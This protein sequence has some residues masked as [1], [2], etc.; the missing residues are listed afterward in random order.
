MDAEIAE[1]LLSPQAYPHHVERVE[2]LQTHISHLFFAGE[3]VY[4]VKKPVDLGF[5]DFT[6]LEKRRHFCEEEVRL[7]SRLSPDMYLGVVPVTREADGS[8]RM[9]GRGAILDWAV[10]MVRLPAERMLDRLLEHAAIDNEQM[11]ALAWLLADFHRRAATGSA[12]DEYGAWEAVRHNAIENFEQTES[13]TGLVV[14]RLLHRHLRERTEEFLEHNRELFERRV[15][16]GRI[17]DGHG[18]LHAGNICFAPGGL[19]VYDCIEFT[20]R[21]RCG[22][23][24]SDLAFLLMDLDLRGFRGFGRYLAH[25]YAEHALDTELPVLLPFYKGYRAM[26]R[27]KVA[28]MRSVSAG[29]G[30]PQRQDSVGEARRYIHLAASYVLPP[31]LL[32]TCGLP[33]TGKSTLAHHLARVLDAFVLRSD[34][35][36]KL[37]AG[38]P[39]TEHAPASVRHM[40]Y[41]AEHTRRTYGHLLAEA[42]VHL[43]QGRPV[44]VDAMFSKREQREPFVKAAEELGAPWAVLEVACPEPTVEERME[45]RTHDPTTVSDADFQVYLQVRRSFEPPEEA[46][47]GHLVQT[48]SGEAVEDVAA[49]LVD[50]LVEQVRPA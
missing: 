38:V 5:L 47:A 13:F 22:D 6:S 7:N 33:G 4:K 8:V 15:R 41:S 49:R 2:T 20:E 43:Q 34:A 29:L 37:L 28:A 39:P 27:A 44:I 35:T 42:R 18:D 45:R 32:L 17:R 1:A 10:Q 36:R 46:A 14:S 24:A 25:R 23:V 9:G 11:D 40:L 48:M 50:R 3:L 16:E 30:E 19:V 31:A 12:V 26:V 21:F